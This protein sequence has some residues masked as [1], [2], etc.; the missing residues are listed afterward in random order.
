MNFAKME[1]GPQP[2]SRTLSE[3]ATVLCALARGYIPDQWNAALVRSCQR[4]NLGF[5]TESTSPRTPRILTAEID[6]W[7]KHRFIDTDLTLP[8]GEP[9][10]IKATASFRRPGYHSRQEAVSRSG[11]PR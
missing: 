10:R 7:L 9:P 3:W 6:A 1:L 8:L 4:G 5:F 2:E 11:R